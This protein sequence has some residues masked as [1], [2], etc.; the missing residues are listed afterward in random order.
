M[1]QAAQIFSH[2]FFSSLNLYLPAFGLMILIVVLSAL[3]FQRERMIVPGSI[4]GIIVFLLAGAAFEYSAELKSGIEKLRTPPPGPEVATAVVEP[5]F[6][7]EPEPEPE[8]VKEKPK[9]APVKYPPKLVAV[10][11]SVLEEA[12][13]EEDRGSG[14][15]IIQEPERPAPVVTAPPV[16]REAPVIPQPVTTPEPE[17][18]PVVVPQPQPMPAPPPVTPQPKPAPTPSPPTTSP[19]T[20]LRVAVA[21]PSATTGNLRIEINGP[22]LETSKTHVPDAHMMIIVGGKVQQTIPPTRFRE[23]PLKDDTGEKV[24]IV[25]VTYFWENVVVTFENLQAGPVSVMIDTA[26]IDKSTHRAN[27]IGPQNTKN[28]WN[29]FIDVKAGQTSRLVFGGKNWMSQQLDKLYPP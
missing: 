26:L 4:V 12:R 2:P 5:E 1:E 29:G 23:D 14:L 25:S 16:R 22:L 11:R 15:S 13:R 7:P 28:D 27:M 18:A 17:P 21:S 3:L 6:V 8:P 9:P 20:N 24:G 10:D 19:S